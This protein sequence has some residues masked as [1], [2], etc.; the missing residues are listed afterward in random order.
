MCSPGR[1]CALPG[2]NTSTSSPHELSTEPSTPLDVLTPLLVLVGMFA[3]GVGLTSCCSRW[4]RWLRRR[5]APSGAAARKPSLAGMDAAD[6]AH[7]AAKGVPRGMQRLEEEG[8]VE[9]A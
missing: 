3:L 4:Q 7:Q 8:A 1:Y 2:A 5:R 9:L 6:A